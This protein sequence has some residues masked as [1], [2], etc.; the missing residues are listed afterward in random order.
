MPTLH[1]HIM[2][3][4]AATGDKTRGFLPN[5]RSTTRQPDYGRGESTR[6]QQGQG[7]TTLLGGNAL[8]VSCEDGINGTTL[9]TRPI[10]HG[11]DPRF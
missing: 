1:S 4:D 6:Y 7:A 11:F 5:H 3:R 2:L 10:S 8:R 9:P